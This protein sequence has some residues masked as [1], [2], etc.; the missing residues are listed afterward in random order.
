MLG[1]EDFPPGSEVSDSQYML[2]RL[3]WYRYGKTIR[4]LLE[5]SQSGKE[6]PGQQLLNVLRE[7][8][9]WRFGKLDVEAQKF[10]VDIQHQILMM[11]GLDLGID[12]LNP[13]ELADCFDALCTCG[14]QHL[15]ENLRK[16]RT[17]LTKALAKAK[18]SGV[19]PDPGGVPKTC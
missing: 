7:Y 4:Q 19:V 17:R 16:L 14:R 11:A 9:K 1:V 6:R 13:E 15:A 10:K 2:A 18:A 12:K 3:S 8:E 5:E